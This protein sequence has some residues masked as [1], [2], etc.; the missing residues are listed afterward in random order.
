MAGVITWF[1]NAFAVVKSFLLTSI[2]QTVLTV[3][4]WILEKVNPGLTPIINLV[5]GWLGMGVSTSD[6]QAHMLTAQFKKTV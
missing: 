1:T 2:G 6:I 3:A 5:L 4:V